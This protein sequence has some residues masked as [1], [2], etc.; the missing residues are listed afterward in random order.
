[1]L[2][3]A[4]YQ[5][6]H[7]TQWLSVEDAESYSTVIY[8]YVQKGFQLTCWAN[9]F[10]EA[11]R[12][13]SLWATNSG[14][15]RC[16]FTLQILILLWLTSTVYWVDPSWFGWGLALSSQRVLWRGGGVAWYSLDP[17]GQFGLASWSLWVIPTG[18]QIP[19]GNFHWLA[20]VS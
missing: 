12:F 15:F 14:P 17:C 6:T 13:V 5:D 16:S 2:S 11:C 3:P 8:P 9:C 7:R 18:Q 19:V 1:M 20:P 10:L 4:L